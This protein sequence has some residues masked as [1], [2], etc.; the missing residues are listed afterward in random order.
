M[1]LKLDPGKYV[2][3]V[4]GGVDSVVLL[5]L[6][7]KQK[8]VELVVAHFDHG[9]RGDSYKDC[10][11]VA[12]LS[13]DVGLPFYSAKGELGPD[14]SEATAREARYKFLEHT[15]A[16]QKADAIVTAHHRDDLLETILINVI[17]GTGR[18]GLSPLRSRK[19][20][21][22]P[23]LAFTKQEILDYAKKHNLRWREDPS[24]QDQKYLRNYLRH[25]VLPKMSES[26][27]QK[28][29]GLSKTSGCHN[30]EIDN[31]VSDL[32]NIHPANQI[33]VAWFR[34]LPNNVACEL[35]SQL[36]RDS[37]IAFDKK[38]I[39]RLVVEVKTSS[40][41]SKVQINSGWNFKIG[42]NTISLSQDKS[43]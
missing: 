42:K 27:R 21:T 11:F 18:K 14:A 40:V 19:N 39:Q 22:R 26:N 20:V 17:R 24:N 31:L 33:N 16:N 38:T 41:N 7:R 3:A 32:L 9:I 30:K 10:D 25:S 35:L 36:L 2:V 43:V 12:K 28:L 13:G 23:L 8:Q 6:L 37:Q 15:I 4:S 29:L 5:H 1:R 34:S